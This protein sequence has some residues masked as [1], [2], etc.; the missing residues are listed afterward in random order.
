M[1]DIKLYLDRWGLWDE[2]RFQF[3][4]AWVAGLLQKLVVAE[5]L[6]KSK[7]DHKPAWVVLT[8]D[9]LSFFMEAEKSNIS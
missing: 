2:V 1:D 5:V 7:V 8:T 4:N 3:I 6:S 9:L